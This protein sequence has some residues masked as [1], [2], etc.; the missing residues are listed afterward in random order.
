VA[1]GGALW[2]FLGPRVDLYQYN[3]LLFKDGKGVLPCRLKGPAAS[4]AV[5]GAEPTIRFGE[6]THPATALLTGAAGAD[7]QVSRYMDLDATGD[8]RVVLSLSNGAPVLVEK[9]IGRGKVL[10]ANFTAGVDWSYLPAMAEFPMLVQELMRYLIG[11]RDSSV[12]LSVGDR[13][14]QPVF[15]ST[16][17]LL[18]RYPDGHKGRFTPQRSEK[19]NNLVLKVDDTRQQGVYEVVDAPPEVLPRLRFVVNQK[20]DS[21]DLSRYEQDEFADSVGHGNWRWIG[22]EAP[23]DELVSRRME[24][25]E[26]APA[27]LWALAI[28]LAVESVL[29]MIFGRRRSGGW[30]GA[31]AGVR[32]GEVAV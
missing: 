11:N 20:G 7:A 30:G 24:V 27:I 25:T 14:Q 8:L 5:N 18:V 21:G 22:P 13:F 19:T 23:F 1:E 2:L 16:Q 28:V 9:P 32:V 4:H 6:S 12:N 3:K 26:L 17:Q 31:G 29:A 15:V 10:L